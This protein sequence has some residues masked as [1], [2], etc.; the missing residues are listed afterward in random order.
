MVYG[1]SM[2]LEDFLKEW[3]D[4]SD[5]VVVHT[6][7]STGVPKP[8][9]VSKSCMETSARR[10]CDFLRL[11][12]GDTALLC[13]PLDYIAGKMVVVRSLVRGLRLLSVEPS[14]HPFRDVDE[15]VSFAALV[16]LQV[17]R[18]LENDVETERMKRVGQLIIGGG[19]IDDRLER[20]LRLFPNPVWS[21]YGMTE[22][23]SHIALRRLNGDEA[24]LWYTPLEGVRVS[25]S[26]R[27]TLRISAEGICDEEIETNDMA[28]LDADGRFRILGRTDNTIDTGGVK[29]QIEEVE[30]IM[31]AA[32]PPQVQPYRDFAVT[33]R[34][35]AVYGEIVVLLVRDTVP[36]ESRREI[37][38]S[39]D[40]LPRYWRPKV[41]VP[42]KEIPLTA[43]GKPDRAAA[44]R[45]AAAADGLPDVGL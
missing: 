11:K 10:T 1:M 38:K 35:D 44:R 42:V 25:L 3:N 24:S 30:R 23:L 16:P 32:L 28:E 45:L 17:V 27:G 18:T 19:A 22:T 34:K 8:M 33:G 29:V 41:F 36:E 7:G 6:S 4:G 12:E 43:T 39:A 20:T 15:P 5:T 37:E 9:S 31:R 21:T 26:P 40:S 2:S 13:M 14:S